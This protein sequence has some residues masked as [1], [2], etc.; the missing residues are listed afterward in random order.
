[1]ASSSVLLPAYLAAFTAVFLWGGTPA[2]TKIAVAGIDPFVVGML[3][4]VLAACVVIPLACLKRLPLPED[5]FDFLLLLLS[6]ACGFIAFTL[7]FAIGVSLT[8][9]SH[10]ALINAGIPIFTGL[11]GAVAERRLP[12]VLWMLGVAISLCGVGLLVLFGTNAADGATLTGDLFCIASSV[13][14]GL[15]YVAGSRLT[16]RLGTMSVTCLGISIAAI[17]QLPI[18][19]VLAPDIDWSAISVSAWVGVTYLSVISTV[20]CYLAWYWALARGGAVRMGPVQFAMPVVSLGL[21]VAIFQETL[22]GVILL[23]A[24]AI[25]VGIGITRRG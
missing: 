2:A 12:G 22:T 18:L 6:A 1:M 10:A 5:R 9:A 23:S 8:S 14:A 3:R 21:S 11:F 20:I 19:M 25:V 13:S 4:T 16:K 7:L 24:V 15:G 17:I